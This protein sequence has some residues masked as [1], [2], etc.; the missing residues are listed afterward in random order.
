MRQMGIGGGVLPFAGGALPFTGGLGALGLG[1]WGLLGGP[2]LG[3]NGITGFAG[4]PALIP[5]LGRRSAE[6]QIDSVETN[7]TISL[8]KQDL[9]CENVKSSFTCAITTNVT[10]I[11]ELREVAPKLALRL[12]P[13]Y[14]SDVTLQQAL[15]V[16]EGSLGLARLIS[17]PKVGEETINDYTYVNAQD[18]KEPRKVLISIYSPEH[19]DTTGFEL[20]E[21]ACWTQF[22][23][24]IRHSKP[25]DINVVIRV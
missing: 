14:V 5:Q 1:P 17:I 3:L 9:V 19:A 13:E 10:N 18:P 4:A 25:T 12:W 21:L 22:E 8:E 6:K 23:T 15:N 7:C 16:E 20:R 11:A 2:W 24:L